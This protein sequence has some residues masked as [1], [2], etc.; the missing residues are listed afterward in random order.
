MDLNRGALRVA[1]VSALRKGRRQCCEFQVQE[2]I[3]SRQALSTYNHGT[4]E[5][6]SRDSFSHSVSARSQV[7]TKLQSR[8][9]DGSMDVPRLGR[10][11]GMARLITADTV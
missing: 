7:W 4:I 11:A 8:L 2:I 5:V 1:D 9:A 10:L 3:P 6:E